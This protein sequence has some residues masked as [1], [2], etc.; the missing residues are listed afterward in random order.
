MSFLSDC[1][2]L[3]E[4]QGSIPCSSMSCVRL[5]AFSFF[6][7]VG[8]CFFV[9][10]VRLSRFGVARVCV[11]EKVRHVPGPDDRYTRTA[12]L[13]A[14]ASAGPQVISCPHWC[15]LCTVALSG[16]SN[17]VCQCSKCA[18]LF[19]VNLPFGPRSTRLKRVALATRQAVHTRRR[20]P[21]L[22]IPYFVPRA[23][24]GIHA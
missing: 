13:C 5:T 23:E 14:R 21:R 6:V 15:P 19:R 16:S 24:Y 9:H 10:P 4:V 1:P 12:V 20:R 17:F 22:T 2:P 18:R 3:G 7:L 11:R 8:F